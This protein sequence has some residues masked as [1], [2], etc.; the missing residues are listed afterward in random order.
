M[1]EFYMQ[2]KQTNHSFLKFQILR[3]KNLMILLIFLNVFLHLLLDDADLE[4]VII[5]IISCDTTATTILSELTN[6]IKK[7]IM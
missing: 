5:R 7:K 3:N 2:R 1:E 6:N 4:K